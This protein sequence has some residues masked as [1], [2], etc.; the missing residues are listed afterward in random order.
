VQALLNTPVIDP[1]PTA[2]RLLKLAERYSPERLE[3]ACA[4]ALTYGETSYTT[5]K[6]ILKQNL[7]TLPIPASSITPPATVFVR[8]SEELLGSLAAVQL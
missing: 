6:G 7:E 3:A 2:R 1:L 5:I 4:R 8:S